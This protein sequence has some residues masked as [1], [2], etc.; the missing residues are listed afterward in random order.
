M[1]KNETVIVE[2]NNEQ[3]KRKIKNGTS[4]AQKVLDSV[5]LADSNRFIPFKEGVLEKSGIIHTV[6]GSGYVV[7]KTPYA[8][9]QYYGHPN[10]SHQ[11]NPNATMKWFETAKARFKEKWIRMVENEYRRNSE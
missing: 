4:N 2:F 5:V 10:K 7:W 9:A 6:I 8:K 1:A 11:K 3:I